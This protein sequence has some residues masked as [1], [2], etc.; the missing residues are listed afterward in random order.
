ASTPLLRLLYTRCSPLAEMGLVI[1]AAHGIDTLTQRGAREIRAARL[2]AAMAVLIAVVSHVAA[3]VVYPRLLPRVRQFMA[4]YDQKNVSFDSAP[5]LRASQI[6]VLP[7]EI[8]F[9]N[10]PALAAWCSLAA[11]TA[12]F[13]LPAWRRHPAGNAT[14]LA[15]NLAPVM[16]VA[17]QFT[18]RQPMEQWRRLQEGGPEQQRLAAKLT[19]TP[20][21]LLEL[22]PGANEMAMPLALPILYRVRAVHGYASVAPH[23][24]AALP[25]A[26]QAQLGPQLSDW[27]YQS[28][29]RGIDAGEFF[30]NATPGLARFQWQ[31]P[32]ARPFTV[33]TNGRLGEVHLRFEPGP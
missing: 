11:L 19:D 29:A 31:E 32:N 21:R 9:R 7:R 4:Q 6:A 24:L 28:S 8:T 26:E 33:G 2:V 17:A 10:P 30:T 5:A 1:L 13:L 20:L 16:M 12:W 18:P 14:L 3:F 22:A 23:C 25:S 15:I 27:I